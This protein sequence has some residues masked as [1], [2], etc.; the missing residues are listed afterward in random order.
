MRLPMKV[1]MA[2]AGVLFLALVIINNLLQT[3]AAPQGMISFQLAGS[4]EQAHSIIRSWSDGRLGLAYTAL[5]LDF[6][7][8]VSYLATLLQL[9]RHFTRDRPGIRERRIARGVRVV[10][11][12]AALADVAENL[13]LLNN[14]NPAT[15]A[16]SLAAAILAL[17]KYTGLILGVAGLVIIRAARRHPLQPAG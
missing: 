7:F 5:W 14:V 15:D 3:A 17:L 4:A 6:A 9:T 2:L 11:V 1:S 13:V 16:L 12:L 10:F 8:I